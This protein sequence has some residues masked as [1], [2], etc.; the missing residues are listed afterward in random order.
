MWP[1]TYLKET[2]KTVRN[3]FLPEEEHY[4]LIHMYFI[5]NFSQLLIFS[6]VHVAALSSKTQLPAKPLFFTAVMYRVVLTSCLCCI[7]SHLSQLKFYSM[8][9]CATYTCYYIHVSVHSLRM[10]E[11]ATICSCHNVYQVLVG[12]V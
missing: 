11:L 7:L 10:C 12:V 8:Q 3:F 9:S 1:Q 2:R 4:Q 6:E 5:A